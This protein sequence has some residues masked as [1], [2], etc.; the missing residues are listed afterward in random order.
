MIIVIHGAAP[1]YFVDFTNTIVDPDQCGLPHLIVELLAK[2]NMD[3]L[4]EL[5]NGKT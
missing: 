1:K 3:I 2:W 5:R 4:I